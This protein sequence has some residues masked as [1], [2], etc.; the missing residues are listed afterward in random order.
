MTTR[1]VLDQAIDPSAAHVVVTRDADGRMIDARFDLAGLPRVDAL[2]AGRPLP[3]VTTLAERLCGICPAA[4]H[5]AGIRARESLAGPIVLPP[6]AVAIRRL[7][8][9]GSIIDMFAIGWTFTAR[10][11]A[12]LLRRFGKAA[13]AAAGSPGH[14]PVTAVPGGVAAPVC[15][16]DLERCAQQLADA[17][18]T[19]SRLAEQSLAE[20]AD[21]TPLEAG[22]A[23]TG[24]ADAALVDADACPDLLGEW[25]RVIAADGTVLI[26]GALADRWGTLVAESRPG[27]AA[28]RPYLVALGP[29]KGA[30]RVGPVAQLRVGQLTT[31]LARELQNEWLRLGGDAEAARAIMTLH[32]VEAIAGLV[33]AFESFD[34][35]LVTPLPGATAPG[36]GVGWVDGARGLLVHVYKVDQAGIVST[37]TILTPTAQ[38]EPWLAELLRTAAGRAEG[39][40][41]LAMEQAIREADPCLPC[42]MVP[43]GSMGLVVDTVSDGAG[44]GRI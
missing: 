36:V 38:N 13:M 26:E 32:C 37:A 42:A 24:L 7:L 17:R 30:Y 41:R 19:A 35:D 34:G 1:R 8:H 28:P 22:P 6:A 31:P 43:V 23:E 18:A 9:W 27:D 12:V 11:E 33:G 20:R 14:F 25:L 44:P 4:H 10:D 21:A 15:V 39:E 40:D 5:L 2:L 3:E 29:G 16:A